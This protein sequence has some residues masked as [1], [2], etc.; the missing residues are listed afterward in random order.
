VGENTDKYDVENYVERK[1]SESG[2]VGKEAEAYRE[3]L[4]DGLR[5]K[6][7]GGTLGQG[8]ILMSDEQFSDLCDRLSLDEIEKYFEIVVE[9]ERKGKRYK[10]KSHY[11]A[12]IDMAMKDRKIQL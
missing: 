1:I 8:I 12:I 11:Q 4:K 2:F 9:C 5:L 10:R 3:E 7:M 6:Y